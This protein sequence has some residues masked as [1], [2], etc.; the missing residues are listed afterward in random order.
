MDKRKIRDIMRLTGAIL[1]FWL[2]IPHLIAYAAGVGRK[3]GGDADAMAEKTCIMIPKHLRLLYFLH[4]NRYFRSLFYHRVGPAIRMLIGWWRPGDR[5]FIL[6]DRMTVGERMVIA[7]PYS[8]I[9]NA[10]SIGNNFSCIHLTTIGDKNG[11]RPRIGNNVTLGAGVVIA[12]DVKIGDNVIIGAGS[13]VLNDV[14]N[15]S[16]AVGNPARVVK[17]LP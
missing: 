12:G 1:F 3:A 7:H 16:V 11:R 4:N 14:P 17:T 15:N 5:Y 10:E 13:I 6:S 2:Y 8:T 9:L